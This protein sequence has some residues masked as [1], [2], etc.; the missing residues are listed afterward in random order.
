MEPS[1]ASGLDWNGPRPRPR[2]RP[3]PYPL[4]TVFLPISTSSTITTG[5]TIDT[6]TQ[7]KKKER[8]PREYRGMNTPCHRQLRTHHQML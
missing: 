1:R 4:T 8:D 3:T 7:E 2:P 6:L 5:D